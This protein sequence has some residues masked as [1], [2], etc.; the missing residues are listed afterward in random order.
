[1]PRCN[2]GGSRCWGVAGSDPFNWGTR[3]RGVG[4]RDPSAAEEESWG[5]ANWLT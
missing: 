5:G 4:H 3:T 2:V 1:M